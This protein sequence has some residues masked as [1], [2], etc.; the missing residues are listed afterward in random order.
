MDTTYNVARSEQPRLG[1]RELLGSI[2]RGEIDM[3][4]RISPQTRTKDSLLK[5]LPHSAH[6]ATALASE[7]LS[8]FSNGPRRPS[9]I[10]C[11]RAGSTIIRLII[12]GVGSF[13]VV[14]P[15]TGQDWSRILMI[16]SGSSAGVRSRG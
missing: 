16:T 13:I 10:C 7:L 14:D 9:S 12:C 8:Q 2:A 3:S 6:P 5:L 15:D 11:P 1:V 4:R